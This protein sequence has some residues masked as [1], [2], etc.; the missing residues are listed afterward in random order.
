MICEYFRN[1]YTQEN[2]ERL[3]RMT[4]EAE[5]YPIG[6]LRQKFVDGLAYICVCDGV[7][8][9]KTKG[10]WG[11]DLFVRK[12]PQ[13]AGNQA[14]T[15]LVE[16]KPVK[17]K[18]MTFDNFDDHKGYAKQVRE[19]MKSTQN[20]IIIFGGP[21]TGKTHLCNA[22]QFS[23]VESGHSVEMIPA[24]KLAMLFHDSQPFRDDHISRNDAQRQINRLK[25]AD[26][27]IIDDLGVESNTQTFRE[28]LQIVLDDMKGRLMVT[29]NLGPM[30]NPSEMQ[31][32]RYQER[33]YSRLMQ[34][35]KT[36]NLRCMDY[37]KKGESA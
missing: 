2:Q 8:H 21:G 35:A 18:A 20:T 32:G 4:K 6:P 26:Y 13:H 28:G 7:D 10:A 23:L 29:T 14:V 31:M 16:S 24:A 30:N 37:R 34:G 27:L 36:L 9:I 15:A 5:G 33:I 3:F 25:S 17:Q 22:A 19:W 12:C 11:Q 1:L